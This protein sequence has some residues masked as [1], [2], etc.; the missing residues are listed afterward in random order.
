M[1]PFLAYRGSG[2]VFSDDLST[3]EFCPLRIP[4]FGMAAASPM[5]KSSKDGAL[6]PGTS[7]KAS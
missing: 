4:P 3:G 5:D 1:M 7:E 2:L 6:S